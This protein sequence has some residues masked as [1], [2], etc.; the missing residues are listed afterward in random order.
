MV[1][2]KDPK[3]GLNLIV[4]FYIYN[5]SI[6]IYRQIVKDIEGEDTELYKTFFVPF[7]KESIKTKNV[8]NAPKLITQ[9]EAPGPEL[10]V[11][12]KLQT[13]LSV[14]SV[15]TVETSSVLTGEIRASAMPENA[16]Q[17]RKR[18]KVPSYVYTKKGSNSKS[19]K[20]P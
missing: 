8:T 9:S 15:A 1:S 16:F 14:S 2:L 11:V 3:G 19:E 4:G 7:D 6:I 17:K 20:N 5:W 13:Y 18:K 10:M 12:Y